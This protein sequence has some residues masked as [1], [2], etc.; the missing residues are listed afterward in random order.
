MQAPTRNIAYQYTL[1]TNLLRYSNHDRSSLKFVP[2][3][4]ETD[5]CTESTTDLVV[6]KR[7]KI[8]DRTLFDDTMSL[9]NHIKKLGD[10]FFSWQAT[11]DS[12]ISY[13][14]E[15]CPNTAQIMIKSN[16]ENLYRQISP[17]LHESTRIKFRLL[18]QVE[19]RIS[20]KLN[21]SFDLNEIALDV[22]NDKIGSKSIGSLEEAKRKIIA[23]SQ[24]ANCNVNAF[25]KSFNLLSHLIENDYQCTWI[26]ETGFDVQYFFL[27][28]R[29]LK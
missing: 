18:K 6:K 26:V 19:R 1:P 16:I 22:L 24:K 23:R 12:Q 10:L 21:D 25:I 28:Y 11:L 17:I 4:S 29:Y 13:C 3:N 9:S 27:G 5:C 8:E 2:R 7:K 14:R 15:G 20:K